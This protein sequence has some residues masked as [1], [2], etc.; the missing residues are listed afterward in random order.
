MNFLFSSLGRLRLVSML[1]GLSLLGLLGIAMP[2]K[3]IF[4]QPEAVRLVGLLHGVL[5]ISYVLLLVQN[6]IEQ[7]WPLTKVGLG[8]LLSVVPFGAFYAERRLFQAT[9]PEP[10]QPGQA[11]RRS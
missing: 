8:L 5:F 11:A 4:Q 1:E 3:Y 6:A 7:R 10:V 2:L 9:S